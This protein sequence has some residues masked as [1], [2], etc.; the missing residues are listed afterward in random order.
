MCIS[1]L[2]AT[3][4]DGVDNNGHGTHVMGTLLG[5]PFD[6]S[7]TYNLDYRSAAPQG[8]SCIPGNNLPGSERP[9]E[10][11]SKS[12]THPITFNGS[13]SQCIASFCT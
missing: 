4:V 1:S 13:A 9:P 8:S 3:Q 6:V 10:D 5:S 7:N 2:H 11:I 12:H